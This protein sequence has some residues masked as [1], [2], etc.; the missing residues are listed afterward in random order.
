MPSVNLGNITKLYSLNRPCIFFPN[1]YIVQINFFH[2]LVRLK[3]VEGKEPL[4][5]GR[6]HVRSS[7]ETSVFSRCCGVQ[8]LKLVDDNQM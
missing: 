3:A 5:I 2:S 1:M 7:Y 4:L 8:K 6:F